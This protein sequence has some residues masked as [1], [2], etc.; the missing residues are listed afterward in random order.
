LL[1]YLQYVH[2]ASLLLIPSFSSV[3]EGFTLFFKRLANSDPRGLISLNG[4]DSVITFKIS[5]TSAAEGDG[6]LKVFSGTS[7]TFGSAEGISSSFLF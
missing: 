7:S 3:A 2:H 6:G 4:G 5:D 1:N